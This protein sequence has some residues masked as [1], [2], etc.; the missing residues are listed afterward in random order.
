KK[1]RC[2]E[3][4]SIQNRIHNEYNSGFVGKELEVICEGYDEVSECF[5]G[6]SYA[7]APDIDGKVYFSASLRVR[8]GEFVKVKIEEVLD[9]D[10]LGKLV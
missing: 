10:L 3:L 1:K 7:D 9:Y 5:Y 8:S 6:R 2:D 4:M